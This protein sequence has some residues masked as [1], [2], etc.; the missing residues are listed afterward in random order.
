MKQYIFSHKD[1]QG[2]VPA[3]LES[4]KKELSEMIKH[5]E[6]TF[7]EVETKLSQ[8]S[9]ELIKLGIQLRKNPNDK[10]L[11]P[12]IDEIK[13]KVK[14][15]TIVVAVKQKI[16]E[17]T[18]YAKTYQSKSENIMVNIEVYECKEAYEGSEDYCEEE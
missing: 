15:L 8:L 17:L 2:G 3:V 12:K 10:S 1:I 16:E 13:T 18:N 7:E 11:K 4:I 5:T 6:C 9:Q 14:S